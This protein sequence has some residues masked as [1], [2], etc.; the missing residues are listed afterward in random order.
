[1][2][3]YLGAA[4]WMGGAIVSFMGMAVAGRAA[5]VELNT[6]EMMT[7]RSFLGAIVMAFVLCLRRGWHEISL[8]HWRMHSARNLSHFV[9]Q[10]L[11]FY[12]LTVMPLAQ[13][14]AFEFTTP[15][16]V[17]LLSPLMLGT[18]LRWP[19]LVAAGVAFVG[20][21]V[22]ARPGAVPIGSGVWAALGCAIGFALPY[23]FTKKLLAYE[24]ISA[25]L[26]QMVIM[27]AT[28]GLFITSF[29]GGLTLP[30]PQLIL[31]LVVITAT[32]L[33]AH[34]CISKALQLAPAS[35]C[36][37]ID[38]IRLPAIAV[39]GAVLYDEPID[40]FVLLGAALIFGGNYMNIISEMKSN[41][42]AS[43]AVAND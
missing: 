21:L 7:Y 1:M 23:F 11:W 9:G 42:V 35:V 31:P 32:G 6:F 16:W 4:L 22:V 13:L 8:R 3:A 20:I 2:N 14:F 36:A 28:L 19:G 5:S 12:A 26:F 33:V 17:I 30:S 25:I 10:N 24:S 40:I 34:L 27:Q 15:I 43:R 41:V 29:D 37:P 38:F 18:K 39:V